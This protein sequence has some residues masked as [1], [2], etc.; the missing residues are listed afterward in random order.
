MCPPAESYN[1]YISACAS[2]TRDRWTCHWG[3]GAAR[4]SNNIWKCL[5]IP[6]SITPSPSRRRIRT[7]LDAL[8]QN[9]SKD[10]WYIY[11]SSTLGWWGNDE[12]ILKCLAIPLKPFQ[13]PILQ[14]EMFPKKSPGR[15]SRSIKEKDLTPQKKVKEWVQNLPPT[16]AASSNAMFMISS[17]EDS[18]ASPAGN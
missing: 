3:G 9:T 10:K 8:Q 12:T 17:D 11:T 5:T 13:N 14:R 4:D 18:N 16:R 2:T 1:N 7:V 6:S 15:L